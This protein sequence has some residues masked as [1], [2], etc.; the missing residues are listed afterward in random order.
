MSD[1]SKQTKTELGTRAANWMVPAAQEEQLWT[2]GT[3]A[4]GINTLPITKTNKSAASSNLSLGVYVIDSL[5]Y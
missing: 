5:S 2:T 1:T 3:W 4:E